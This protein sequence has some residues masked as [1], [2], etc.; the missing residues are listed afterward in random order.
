MLIA[1]F[2]YIISYTFDGCHE[3]FR[4]I[5]TGHHLLSHLSPSVYISIK[6]RTIKGKGKHWCGL[7]NM[8]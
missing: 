1:I 3:R 4:K 7:K 2:K 5:V 6:I 8:I